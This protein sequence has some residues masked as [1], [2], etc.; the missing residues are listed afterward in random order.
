MIELAYLETLTDRFRELEHELSDP[1]AL[2]NQ[3]RYRELVREH[4]RYRKIVDLADAYR[5]ARSDCDEYERC[6][7]DANPD[8][9]LRGI[10]RAELEGVRQRLAETE[11][12]LV[13]ALLPPD[14]ND[15]RNVVMEI[16]AGTGGDEAALFA[17]DLFRMYSRY[18]E[19]KGWSVNVVDASPA[20]VG[21]Y[22]EIV[23][24]VTDP[25]GTYNELKYESGCHRVQRV[26]VT[27]ASGRIHTSAATVAV[28][29]EA[30]EMDDIQI[31]PGELR[32]D[33]FCAS[34][35]GGQGVNTT[36]SAV[37]V[38]HLPT[39][40]VAQSQDERS[41]QRN[42]EKALNVMK[43][44]LL[45]WRRQQE[46]DKAGSARRAQIGSGDRSEKIRTYNF[47]QNRVTDH[48]INLTLY[49]LDRVINGDLGPL[50]AAL[51]ADDMESKIRSL[52]PGRGTP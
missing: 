44:R 18:L 41:Q 11:T 36:Y 40:L 37:R 32:I 8:A 9:E 42:R 43:A 22:K 21:G 19:A 46:V 52:A 27:E 30:D 33:I 24:L 15:Q 23:F 10:A 38:T 28:L 17:G 47:P 1:A 26:P 20:P 34:G 25:G 16:R 50:I 7:T 39:G 2:A 4:L 49:T 5:R 6:D 29:P 13:I 3:K 31:P 51:K 14:P 12:K 45:D 35:P 48:R